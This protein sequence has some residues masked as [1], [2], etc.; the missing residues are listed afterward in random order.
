MN[1]LYVVCMVISLFCSSLNNLKS[2]EILPIIRIG[3]IADIQYGDCDSRGSRFYRNSLPKLDSCMV[4]FNQNHVHFIVNLG[5]LVDRSPNDIDAV[6]S[7]LKQAESPVYNI[8]GNHDYGGFKDNEALYRK[9]NM[10][11][12]YYSLLS[13]NWRFILLNTNEIASYANV[14]ETWKE[15][16]LKE[17]MDHLKKT[18]KKNGQSYNGGISSIQLKWLEDQLKAAEKNDENV[19]IFSHHPLYPSSAY[20]ALN[21]EAI[22]NTVSE[23]ECVKA[24]ISGHHH[25]GAFG[26]YK[27]IPCITTEGMIETEN[28]NAYGIINIFN[29]K[30][31]LEGKGRTKTYE[32]PLNSTK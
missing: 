30:I 26:N 1:K 29:D 14:E 9:L 31:V 7:I 32:I 15:K 27:N 4:D 19:I 3:L 2:Q 20:T 22:L 23:F 28:T 6:L 11:Q 24:I 13:Q 17:Q 12:E 8:T 16:E 18:D 21:D 5:D 25:T 10:P